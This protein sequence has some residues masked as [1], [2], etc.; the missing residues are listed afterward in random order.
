[1]RPTVDSIVKSFQNSGKKHFLITGNRGSG[2]TTLFLKLKEVLCNAEKH[3][4]PEIMTYLIPQ[5]KVILR[6]VLTGEEDTIGI[7]KDNWM[8]T[9]SS[10]FQN[11]GVRSVEDAI[12]ADD[13]KWAAIDEI[14]FLESKEERF[15]D[16]VRKLF[17]NKKI[18]AVIRKQDIPFLNELKNREDVY[19]VDMDEMHLCVGCIIMASGISKRFGGNKLLADFH[20]ETL[21]ERALKLTEGDLFAK[22]IVVTRTKEVELI[23]KR[24]GIEVILHE[25]PGRGDAIKLG[26]DRMRDTDACI[27]CPCDQPLLKEESLKSLVNVFF[28]DSNKIYRLAWNECPGTPVLFPKE[29]YQELL[30]LPS[31]KGGSHLMKKYRDNIVLVQVTDENELKDVDTKEDLEQMLCYNK[32]ELNN[33]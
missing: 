23:C 11:L 7:F 13:S 2:K 28:N 33:L 30:D 6:N 15:K 19:L 5:E 16:A 32:Y 1:M 18:L 24:R 17:A 9:V 21:V 20:G 29:Y 10:G 27:F 3:N 4:I 12:K 14:G 8:E 26:I 25:F 22:R 31:S